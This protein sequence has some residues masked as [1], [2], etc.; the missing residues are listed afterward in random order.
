MHEHL[1]SFLNL[2]DQVCNHFS[3]LFCDLNFCVRSLFIYRCV[4]SCWRLIEAWW[5]IL[6]LF[7]QPGSLLCCLRHSWKHLGS[8]FLHQLWAALPWQ[9]L[10]PCRRSESCC[11]SW[12]AMSRMQNMS[13]VQVWFLFFFPCAYFWNKIICMCNFT[14]RYRYSK[15]CMLL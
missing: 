7:S 14:M 8:T 1:N 12:M 3:V 13:D 9:L 5:N 11:S 6:M 2:L 10:R 15:V 4:P